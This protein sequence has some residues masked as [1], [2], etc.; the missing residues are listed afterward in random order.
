MKAPRQGAFL[1]GA[2]LIGWGGPV[3]APAAEPILRIAEIR[4]LPRSEAAK[5]LPVRVRGVVTWRDQRFRNFTLQDESA[6]IWVLVREAKNLPL[7]TGDGVELQNI[8]EGTE[9]EI[10]GVTNAGGFSPVIVPQSFVVRGQRPLPAARPMDRRRFFTG[11]EANQR[12]EVQGVVQ[13]FHPTQR[14]W[15][16]LLDAVPGQIS[17]EVSRDVIAQPGAIVDAEVRLRGVVASS[18]NTRGEL[19]G[20]RMLTNVAGDLVVEKPAPPPESVPPVAL[21]ALW[22]F[23]PEPPSPHRVR[24]QGTVTFAAPGQFVYVQEG[25]RAVRV[26]TSPTLALRMGDRVELWGF[27]E[28]TRHIGRL[29]G[30]EGRKIGEAE[31]PAAIVTNPEQVLARNV[32]A[33]D[34]GLSAQPHDFDGHLIRFRARLLTVQPAPDG[35]KTWRRLTL[36]QGSLVLS[37]TLQLGDVQALDDLQ[38]GSDVELTGIV[39]LEYAQ[40]AGAGQVFRPVGLDVLLRDPRD[41]VV[42]RAPSWWT[43]QRLLGLVALV[44]LTLG[45]ALLWAWQLRRQVQRKTQQLA[46]EM[47]ARRDAAIEFQATLRERN[48]LA[49]NLHDTLLQTMGGIGF[50]LEACDA[51]AAAP[52]EEG[53][54]GAHL[55]VARRMLDHAVNELR[56]SVWALRSLPMQGLTLPKALTSL[57]EQAGS[58]HE[59]RIEVRTE[60]DFS[61]VPDFV[62]GNLLLAAQEALHN[63]LKHGR[64]RSVTFEARPAEPAGWIELMVRDDGVGFTPG[65]QAGPAQGHFGLAGMRER[66][67]RLDGTL[68]IE[69]AP[70]RGTTLHFRVPLRAYDGDLA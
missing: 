53:K 55:Q 51:E 13:G 40:Q 10:V 7:S 47:H 52:R 25:T 34:S 63:A 65:T 2:L 48:R 26:E 49:A 37:A 60:G 44:G 41:V 12:I 6:G 4:A 3:V 70:G 27:V 11:A 16:L 61:Q 9:L 1:A 66:M 50:Q 54:L 32:A 45:A 19:I 8:R 39:Q 20:L 56:A 35:R 64:P 14:G 30:G 58:G 38:A 17:A 42:V 24:I 21:D 62:A 29:V 67:E 57:A 69:S 22:P 33:A 31:V 5:A 15:Q 36:E 59:A 28:M 43:A 68:R 46:V 23:S 18:F